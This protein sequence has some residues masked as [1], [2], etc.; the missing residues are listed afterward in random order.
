MREALAIWRIDSLFDF[1]I[2]KSDTQI[3]NEQDSI[4]SSFSPY[5]VLDKDVEQK[6]YLN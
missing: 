1:P 5:Y 6:C 3:R 2:Y 4:L